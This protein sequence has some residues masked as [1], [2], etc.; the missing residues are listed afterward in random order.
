VVS[1]KYW[2]KPIV[3]F[4]NLV[5]QVKKKNWVEILGIRFQVLPEVFSPVYSS[6]TAWF[7]EK[8]VPLTKNKKFLEIGSGAGVIACLAS[9][10]G[11]AHVTATDINP[12][13]I[14]NI[15][16]NTKLHSTTIIVKEGSV[17]DPITKG[18]LFDV[19]F[20]N[21]PFYYTHKKFSKDDRVALSVYDTEYQFLKKF[22]R[23]GKT[24]LDTKG[25]L[26]LG[27]SN[28]ARI[29]LI[30]QLAREEGYRASLL[31]K[32]EVPIYKGKKVKMDLRIYAFERT[33]GN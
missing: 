16:V 7:A 11:A 28:V 13:A 19:I 15:L 31:E 18:E 29:N 25:K 26:L 21:H 14:E 20:W 2:E 24:Y 4:V 27:T 6:D 22:L 1:K 17:F 10:N 30:K 5:N 9:M 3:E 12:K 32:V 23:D 8:L 33:S